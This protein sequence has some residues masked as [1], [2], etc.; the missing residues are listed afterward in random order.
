MSPTS[1]S[2]NVD[3]QGKKDWDRTNGNLQFPGTNRNRLRNEGADAS[4]RVSEAD[5]S[6]IEGMNR[7]D[8]ATE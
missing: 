8:L 6:D 2:L 1:Q 5:R 4:V 7:E 3:H